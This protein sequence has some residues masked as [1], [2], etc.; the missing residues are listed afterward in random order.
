MASLIKPPLLDETGKA[1]LAALQGEEPAEQSGSKIR[2][3]M[4][5]ETGKAILEFLQNGGGGGSEPFVVT[6]SGTTADDNA[7]CDKT[8]AEIGEA[9]SAGKSIEARYSYP[10]SDGEV[11]Y[12][13]LLSS[14]EYYAPGEVT[15]KCWL[16][17]PGGW[18]PTTHIITEAYVIQ[19]K[20]NSNGV[21]IFRDNYGFVPESLPDMG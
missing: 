5:D 18:N 20:F 1:I 17:V 4:S 11:S 21:D 15:L 13:Q 12:D 16:F 8:L 9:I 14:V 19:A 7:A 6:F 3:P 2:A 10:V